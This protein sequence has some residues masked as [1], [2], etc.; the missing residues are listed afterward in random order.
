LIS[1]GAVIGPAKIV[2]DNFRSLVGKEE[3]MFAAEAAT[4]T[5]DDRNSSIE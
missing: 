2:Y 5:G 1:S 4:G 3:R